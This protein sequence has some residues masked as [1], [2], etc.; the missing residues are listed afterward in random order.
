[1]S[2]DA[3]TLSAVRAELEPLLVGARMQKVVLPDQLSLALETFAP[4]AGRTNV[5]F[6]AHPEDSRVQRIPSLPAP[7]IEHDTP[8]SLLVRKHLRDARIRRV[9][10]PRLER[11]LE[12]DCEQRDDSGEHYRVVLI[13]EA[14]G[15]RSNLVLVDEQ[16]LILDAMRRSP[17]S[18]NSRRPVLPHL[19]YVS[20]PAQDRLFPED[21]S[22]EALASLANGRSG[23]LARF[24]SDSLAG[25]SPLAGRELAFRATGA[26][27]TPRDGADWTHVAQV[28]R[29][30]LGIVD[31]H[32]W[33]PTVAFEDDRPIDFAPYGL[34][35]LAA[36]GARLATYDSMSAAMEACYAGRA[37]AG[38]ARRGDP[39]AAERRTLLIPL[40]RTIA[41]TARRIAALEHQLANGHALRAPLRRAGELILTHQGDLLAGSTELYVDGERIQLDGR[42]SA[43]DNAQ[44]YFARY[45]KAREAEERVPLLLEQDRQRAAHLADL[46]TLVELADGMDSVRALRREVGR[47]SGSKPLVDAKA[48][49]RGAKPEAAAK[50]S[51][52]YRRVALG[53]GWEALVG[54]S[55]T[56]N[57]A[58]TFDLAQAADLWLHA[59]GVPGAHVILRTNG[60]TPSDE[61]V[62]RAAVL[63]AWHSAART[64]GAVEVDVAP[65]RY[66]KKIPNA[67][68][69]LVRYSNERTVRVTPSALEPACAGRVASSLP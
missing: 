62:E 17:P 20:P 63:A 9:R 1:M 69:G 24:L 26:V 3:L 13:V 6:T 41:T 12:L 2:F 15:R 28:A 49:K 45:R 35:H 46:C 47:A 40:E 4:G 5:L 58:V 68:P 56:G 19:P 32:D 38:P 31:A 29:A 10:Q 57:A 50:A 55:A 22:A 21:V 39:L 64:S 51:G 36:T 65:R 66:V 25:L 30:F 48:P 61:V 60:A 27:D 67:P 42:L 53:D 54:T 14:M 44:A 23:A 52:P 18:R 11:V 8:F 37:E 43:A 59:R 16:G 7:G 33:R 34:T